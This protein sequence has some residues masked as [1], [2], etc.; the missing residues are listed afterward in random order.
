MRFLRRDHDNVGFCAFFI[1]EKL[2]P[3][4]GSA[5]HETIRVTGGSG[6]PE[7]QL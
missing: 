3:D 4:C 7:P 5:K 1:C 6:A 2:R